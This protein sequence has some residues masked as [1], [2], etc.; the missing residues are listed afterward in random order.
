MDDLPPDD[1]A[2]APAP[3]DEAQASLH[4]CNACARALQR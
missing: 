2:T 1:E 3:A 4:L